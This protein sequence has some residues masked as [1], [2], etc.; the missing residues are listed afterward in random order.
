MDEK[1]YG[2]RGE[3][4]HSGDSRGK[5]KTSMALDRKKKNN[6]TK[7]GQ[8]DRIISRK[9]SMKTV[10]VHQE[11]NNKKRSKQTLKIENNFLFKSRQKYFS[12]FNFQKHFFAKQ[13]NVSY[14]FLAYKMSLCTFSFV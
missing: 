7:R 13:K 1:K 8:V 6:I 12:F 5:G 4:R 14:T 10:D 2:K 3:N 11:N 9:F